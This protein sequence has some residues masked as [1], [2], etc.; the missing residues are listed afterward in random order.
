ME[1][2]QTQIEDPVSVETGELVAITYEDIET[3]E[4]IDCQS[5]VTKVV[6][7]DGWE[8]VRAFYIE[9]GGRELRCRVTS[10]TSPSV[11]LCERETARRK[12]VGH[13]MEV[14]PMGEMTIRV[15]DEMVQA[16]M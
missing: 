1:F 16:T 13:L 11:V 14:D 12:P 8:S 9:S 10:G 7:P 6:V 2:Y 15:T 5:T 3:G 4:S